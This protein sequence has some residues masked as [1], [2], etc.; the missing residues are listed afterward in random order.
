MCEVPEYEAMMG[1]SFSEAC[2]YLDAHGISYE[3][4]TLIDED[5]IPGIV[6][7]EYY[8]NDH[9]IVE[10]DY[11]GEGHTATVTGIWYG[12]EWD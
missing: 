3:A 12:E 4:D 6:I 10:F 7:G 2:A 9:V 1:M 8:S 5:Y 11:M